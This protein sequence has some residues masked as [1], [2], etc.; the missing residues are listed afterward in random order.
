M[1]MPSGD[2]PFKD[3]P[4]HNPWILVSSSPFDDLLPTLLWAYCKSLSPSLINTLRLGAP[5]RICFP[6]YCGLTASFSPLPVSSIATRLGV[7][8]EVFA[9]HLTVGLLQVLSPSLDNSFETGGFLLKIGFPPYCGLTASLSL[10]HSR[11]LSREWEGF[12]SRPLLPTSLW[13]YC[14]FS[15]PVSTTASRL[16]VP[17]HKPASHFTVGLL[18]V[19][20]FQSC[21]LG[22]TLPTFSTTFESWVPLFF[23]HNTHG[24]YFQAP[25][26]LLVTH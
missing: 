6:L 20:F 9:S 7:F 5:L 14:K 1:S 19:L 17:F 2:S 4:P 13:A 24:E 18:H 25:F 26:R 11:Q 15:P 3:L 16:G 23:S 22:V 21:R 8:F 10:S 12:L